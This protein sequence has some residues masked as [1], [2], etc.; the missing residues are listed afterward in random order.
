MKKGRHSTR[1]WKSREIMHW[2][3]EPETE[4]NKCQWEDKGQFPHHEF[5]KKREKDDEEK[6]VCH[7]FLYFLELIQEAEAQVM[8]PCHPPAVCASISL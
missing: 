7:H 1:L 3:G 8:W 6:K 5:L 2:N 4:M